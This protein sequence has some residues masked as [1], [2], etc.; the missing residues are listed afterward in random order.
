MFAEPLPGGILI[1]ENLQMI[2]VADLLAGVDVD[3]DDHLL[4]PKVDIRGNALPIL[5]NPTHGT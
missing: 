4:F 2:L 3:S 1:G 5:F